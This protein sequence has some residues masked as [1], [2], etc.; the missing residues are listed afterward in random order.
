MTKASYFLE[1]AYV[2]IA[3]TTITDNAGAGVI[4]GDLSFARLL[5]DASIT[6]NH[7]GTDVGC[8]PRVF[9]D[10]RRR[11]H[12]RHD[13]SASN[14]KNRGTL[15]MI[16]HDGVH[17]TRAALAIVGLASS[18]ILLGC[19]GGSDGPPPPPVVVSVSAQLGTVEASRRG[20]NLGH[21]GK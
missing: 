5:D 7:G 3:S 2:Q 21:R 13:E 9:G 10:P 19:S 6:G 4:V 1:G 15:P 18:S 11:R 16:T 17:P 14:P 12:W 8:N 20:S